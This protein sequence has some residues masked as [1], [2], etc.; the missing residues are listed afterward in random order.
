MSQVSVSKGTFYYMIKGEMA[1][2]VADNDS[3]YLF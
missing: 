3:K 2:E 1:D